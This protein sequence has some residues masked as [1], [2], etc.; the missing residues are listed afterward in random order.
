MDKKTLYKILGII[1][2]LLI[3]GFIVYP[4]F[5]NSPDDELDTNTIVNEKDNNM[6]RIDVLSNLSFFKILVADQESENGISYNE[7]FVTIRDIEIVEQLQE[8]ISTAELYDTDDAMGY[9]APTTAICYLD[10]NSMY[11]FFVADTNLVVFSD[12]DY[13]KIMY[14]LDSKYNIEDFLTK[15]YNTNINSY[16]YSTFMQNGKY[17]VK[18]KNKAIISAEYDN[19]ALINPKLD[20]FAIT[21]DN[22]TSF[23]DKTGENPFPN[24]EK[25]QVISG[26]AGGESLWYENALKFEI[27]NK[28]GLISLDGSILLPAEYDEINALNYAEGYLVI[29]QNGKEKVLKILSSGYEEVTGEFDSIKI[30]GADIEYIS[31]DEHYI[32]LNSTVIVGINDGIREQYFELEN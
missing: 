4:V 21:Q 31:K 23:I 6:L 24:F 11:S 30:L 13:N 19:I 20:V 16:N 18:Y 2:M 1:F 9:D 5:Y 10:D 14:K 28:Y 15:L 29:S 7:K 22:I 26:T 25:V 3:L 32:N 12:N 8:I 27:D 17:G